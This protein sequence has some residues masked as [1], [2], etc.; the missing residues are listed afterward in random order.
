MFFEQQSRGGQNTVCGPYLPHQ[1]H[2][3]HSTG[4]GSGL[5]WYDREQWAEA[6][7]LTQLHEVVPGQVTFRWSWGSSACCSM[8]RG[9]RPCHHC[10]PSTSVPSSWPAWLQQ[11]FYLCLGFKQ[12]GCRERRVKDQQGSPCATRW[13]ELLC[14]SSG[15]TGQWQCRALLLYL[16]ATL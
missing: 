13:S 4:S 6:A 2:L 14:G 7:P 16:F 15:S 3:A 8:L 9:T 1:F 11:H 10:C 12:D 5:C